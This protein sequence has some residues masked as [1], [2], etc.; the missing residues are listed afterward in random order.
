MDV[1]TPEQ[2][3][4]NMSQIHSKD[5]K[6][7]L[8]VRKWLWCHGYRYRLHRKDLPGKPD[9]VLPKY[10]AVIFVHGCFWHR[11]NCKYAS[12]PATRKDFW[13]EKLNGNVERDKVNVR[14]LIE[15]KWRVLVIWECEIKKWDT[16]LE[17]KIINF[18][19][20]KNNPFV[21]DDSYDDSQEVFHI[22]AESEIDYVIE[23]V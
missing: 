14:K 19:R 4:Y 3:H 12:T 17:E 15:L 16:A 18:L 6:P 23:D 10:N 8:I 7:E 22:A 9:I 13:E 5:T 11:H 21:Q 1:L 20:L 2:R